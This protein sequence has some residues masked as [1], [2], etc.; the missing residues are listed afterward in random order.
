MPQTQTQPWRELLKNE[1]QQV[2]A[3][4]EVNHADGLLRFTVDSNGVCDAAANGASAPPPPPPPP[5][6]A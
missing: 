5:G 2:P 4:E 3:T 6:S 1:E